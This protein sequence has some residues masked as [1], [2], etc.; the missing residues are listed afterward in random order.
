MV[1]RVRT[2]W[3]RLRSSWITQRHDDHESP[4]VSGQW[5]CHSSEDGSGW[6][7][8]KSRSSIQAVKRTD[9]QKLGSQFS[10][11]LTKRFFRLLWGYHRSIWS[12][13]RI[14]DKRCNF[15]S[16]GVNELNSH[17][18]EASEAFVCLKINDS[19]NILPTFGNYFIWSKFSK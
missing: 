1:I 15:T 11:P 9:A 16:P 12:C 6:T 8:E 7:M 10:L 13:L 5:S 3:S 17:E 14:R 2:H 19:L 4:L 18:I